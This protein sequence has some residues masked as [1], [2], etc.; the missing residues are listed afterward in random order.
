MLCAPVPDAVTEQMQPAKTADGVIAT[1]KIKKAANFE[2]NDS[3]RRELNT[4]RA[5]IM[6]YKLYTFY[7]Q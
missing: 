1:K 2:K 7:G 4:V 6:I 3:F 5:K